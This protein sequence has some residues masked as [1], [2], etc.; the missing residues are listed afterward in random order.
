MTFD[1]A[2]LFLLMAAIFALFVLWRKKGPEMP[3]LPVSKKSTLFEQSSIRSRMHKTCPYF[4]W[5]A[6]VFIAFSL[7]D[8]KSIEGKTDRESEKEAYPR[9]GNALYFLI[10]Q[11]GSMAEKVVSENLEK[12][13]KLEIA[14]EAVSNYLDRTQ[15]TVIGL[16]AFAR[17]AQ[18]L[19]PLTLDRDQIEAKLAVI[20]PVTQKQ[21]NGTAIG[22]AIFKTVNTIVATKYFAERQKERQKPAYSIENQAIIVISDGLQAPHPDDRQH[23]FR[24]IPV[25]DALYYAAQNNVRVYFIGVDPIFRR[26]DAQAEVQALSRQID[27]TGGRLFVMSQEHA[28]REIFSDIQALEKSPY[29]P[30][31]IEKAKYIYKSQAVIF[32]VLAIVFLFCAAVIETLFAKRVP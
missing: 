23:P 32:I 11:S 7:S 25:E 2:T 19:S 1:L 3:F 8:P 21:F 9:T 15:D 30:V 18:T 17:A 10:D 14:K 26:S 16:V 24:Y 6:L 31:Q 4:F 22:Y 29:T 27:K 12:Q 28:L 5:L 20:E 13:T